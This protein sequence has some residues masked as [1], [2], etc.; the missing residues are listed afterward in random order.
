MHNFFKKVILFEIN[1]KFSLYYYFK[2]CVIT[3][4]ADKQFERF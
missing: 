3:I 4:A 1:L 2:K